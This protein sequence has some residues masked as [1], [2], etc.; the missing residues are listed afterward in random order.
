MSRDATISLVFAGDERPF[1]LGY[2]NLLALQD[3]CNAG[4]MEIYNRLASGN[5]RAQDVFE[6]IR[7]GLIGKGVDPKIAKRLVEEN[8]F[9]I[10]EPALVAQA[11]LATAIVGDPREKVGEPADS[12]A[13]SEWLSA[14]T[15]YEFAGASGRSV[16]ELKG[17]SLWE[18]AALVDGWNNSLSDG[19]PKAP[20]AERH[21]ELKRLHGD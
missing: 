2:D 16:E 10:A 4:Y 5:A 12:R 9:P 18:I 7:L 13:A 20:T 19:R 15:M 3:A 8:I 14:A 21:D 6:T 11:I 1:R 17:L